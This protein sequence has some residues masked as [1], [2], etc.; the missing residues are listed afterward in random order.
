MTSAPTVE[1]TLPAHPS[2]LSIARQALG[3]IAVAE[4]WAPSFLEDATL[5]LSEACSNVVMHAYPDG[6]GQMGVRLELD[7]DT[8]T[9]TVSDQGIGISPRLDNP[10]AGLGLGLPLIAA[11][12]TE[13]RL[14][15]SR[16]G[17]TELTMVLTARPD[18][19][20]DGLSSGSSPRAFRTRR[21]LPR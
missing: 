11:I 20:P 4:A 10:T 13:L 16:D 1:M 21:R 18:A 7:G 15:T 14:H 3:A 17:R 12:A 8:V 6:E 9:I 5:A 2:S 19:T